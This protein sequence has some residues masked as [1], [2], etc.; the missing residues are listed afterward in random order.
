MI[1]VTAFAK[2]IGMDASLLRHHKGGGVYLSAKQVG[3]IEEGLHRLGRE[4][5]AVR[6]L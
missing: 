5:S 1:N 3:R 4:L 2:L 6:L